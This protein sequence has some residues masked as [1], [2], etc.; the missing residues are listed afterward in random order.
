VRRSWVASIHDHLRQRSLASTA[1]RYGDGASAWSS[2]ILSAELKRDESSELAHVRSPSNGLDVAEHRCAVA[3]LVE[4][5][6][7]SVATSNPT[8][9][10]SK[11]GCSCLCV[12]DT[13]LRWSSVPPFINC[14]LECGMSVTSVLLT[15]DCGDETRERKRPVPHVYEHSSTQPEGTYHEGA[16][17]V[18][19]CPWV[20]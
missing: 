10:Q 9:N 13:T 16:V 3:S 7:T 12:T 19:G 5:S 4:Q 11:A 17:T 20:P 2:L 8:R 14:S 6:G 15:P 1:R 18:Q